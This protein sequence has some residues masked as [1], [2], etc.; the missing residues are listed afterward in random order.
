MEYTLKI[1]KVIVERL[2]IAKILGSLSDIGHK[3]SAKKSS[4]YYIDKNEIR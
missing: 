3:K 2:T 4:I 1:E